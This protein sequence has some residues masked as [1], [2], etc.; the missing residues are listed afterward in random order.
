MFVVWPSCPR[1]SVSLHPGL[2]LIRPLQG[3]SAK[4][5]DLTHSQ[6]SGL[7]H[8]N[9]PRATHRVAPRILMPFSE[10]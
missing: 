9:L 3:L 8:L 7:C 5:R 1:G 4:V 6:A 10:D 2:A